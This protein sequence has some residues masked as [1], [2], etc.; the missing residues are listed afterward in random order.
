MFGTAPSL[1]Y[2][3]SPTF[4]NSYGGLLTVFCSVC[5][6]LSTSLIIWR[7]F[8]RSSP[9]TNINRIF[10]KN[11]KGFNITQQTLPFAFGV[12]NSRGT[13]YI[14]P[15]IYTVNVS[16]HRRTTQT[17]NGAAQSVSTGTELRVVTCDT[18]GL[19]KRYFENV[20][21][22]NMYCIE[23]TQQMPLE[24]TGVFE[25]SSF[26]FLR[27]HVKPCKG[28][29]TCKTEAEVRAAMEKN[30]FAINYFGIGIKTS[31]F[32]DPLERYPTSYFTTVSAGVAKDLQIRM[33]NQEIHTQS[34]AFG[35]VRPDILPF[36]SISNVV[37]DISEIKEG[38]QTV[39]TAINLSIR[40]NQELIITNR[41]YKTVFQYL[42]ELGGL[43]NVIKIL[44]ILLIFRVA[45][46]IL[47]VDFVSVATLKSKI[48]E[49]SMAA[50]ESIR[51]SSKLQKQTDEKRSEREDSWPETDKNT[52]K[53]LQDKDARVSKKNSIRVA[54]VAKKNSIVHKYV[55]QSNEPEP[56]TAKFSAEDLHKQQIPVYQPAD[57]SPVGTKIEAVQEG[58][59]G[60]KQNQWR[61]DIQKEKQPSRLFHPSKRSPQTG[62][63]HLYSS[64]APVLPVTSDPAR[65]QE[66]PAV[67]SASIFTFSFM[68][69]CQKKKSNIEKIKNI[70]HREV[71]K[72]LDYTLLVQLVNQI[73]AM[74]R[75]LFDGDQRVLFELIPHYRLNQVRQTCTC[76]DGEAKF[77]Q[78]CLMHQQERI[79]QAV[80]SILSKPSPSDVDRCIIED[81]EELQQSSSQM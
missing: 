61:S 2:N 78:E 3:S 7:Y 31:N 21:L 53:Q 79:V 65:P 44:S 1:G 29:A 16:Y 68:P 52:D 69:F 22:N 27:I 20:Q 58:E 36:T 49:T 46:T 62:A 70:Y 15:S 12:Q 72:K 76:A 34:S 45:A 5:Y 74:K 42:A 51:Q 47:M 13:H 56:H 37:S 81:L 75:Y 18:V 19:D 25:S 64:Q 80:R 57:Q 60:T 26:G 6:M 4:K 14:D 17:V 66:L 40:M 11:P 77:V 41:A 43:F 50:L 30:Y 39:T 33:V 32:S 63:S 38:S 67:S 24:V 23:K 55:L 71:E 54:S 59:S 9:E 35:Y 28:A 10:V 48:F 8:E 73:E